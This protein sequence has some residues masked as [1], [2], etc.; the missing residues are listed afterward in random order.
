MK[1]NQEYLLVS[2]CKHTHRESKAETS[3]VH[4]HRDVGPWGGRWGGQEGASQSVVFSIVL[5]FRAMKRYY[6]LKIPEIECRD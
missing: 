3:Q 5:N 4:F 1:K 6:I 2:F